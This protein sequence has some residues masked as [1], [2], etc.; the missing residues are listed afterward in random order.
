MPVAALTTKLINGKAEQLQNGTLYIN[1]T[2][3]YDFVGITYSQGNREPVF[4]KGSNGQ[5]IN[6]YDTFVDMTFTITAYPDMVTKLQEAAKAASG[7]PGISGLGQ[8]E[9]K[10]VLINGPLGLKTEILDGAFFKDTMANYQSTAGE[11]VEISGIFATYVN[12][13]NRG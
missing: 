11:T 10:W 7:Y 8:C 6:A 2:P 3:F 13:N 5:A 4:T 9:L 1:N 12:G